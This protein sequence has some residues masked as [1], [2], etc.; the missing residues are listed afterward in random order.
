MKVERLSFP[1]L[2]K[3][4]N[5]EIN[6]EATCIVKF[7]SNDCK[8][9]H[10][11]QEYYENIAESYDD[12][13]FFAFNTADT[14]AMD[15]YIKINGVPSIALIQNKKKGAPSIHILEDPHTPNKHTWYRTHEIR[16]FIEKNK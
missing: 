2:R 4:L 3:I 14:S 11:L 13:Y 16:H 12:V 10:A 5:G 7:Y 8:Y 9:C 6:E 1:A 15:R